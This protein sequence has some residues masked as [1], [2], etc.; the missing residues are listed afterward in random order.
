MF[1]KLWVPSEVRQFYEEGKDT[2]GLGY[3]LKQIGFKKPRFTR[4]SK[5][6]KYNCNVTAI[7]IEDSLDL[8]NSKIKE[9]LS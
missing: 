5:V 2:H 8:D 6:P 1:E 7:M 9:D 4:I 3:I